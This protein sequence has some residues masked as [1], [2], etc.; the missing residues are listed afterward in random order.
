MYLLYF[1][2]CDGNGVIG[3]PG[4]VFVQSRRLLKLSD[5][6]T[7]TIGNLKKN[8][9]ILIWC[10]FVVL[11]TVKAASRIPVLLLDALD[12][13]VN[14]QFHSSATHSLPMVSYQELA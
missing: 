8:A 7:D 1:L 13:A 3:T 11:T 5:N 12:E 14:P 6:S 9:K 4:F 10:V 2:F